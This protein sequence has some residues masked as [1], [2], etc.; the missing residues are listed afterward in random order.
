[1]IDKFID[2]LVKYKS[3][4]WCPDIAFNINNNIQDI[5]CYLKNIKKNLSHKIF[6]INLSDKIYDDNI[7]IDIQNDI[8]SIKELIKHFEKLKQNI[9]DIT[10]RIEQK[11]IFDTQIYLYVID[12]N[13]CPECNVKLYPLYIDYQK[14]I[15][16]NIDNYERIEGYECQCCKK[17]FAMQ[18]DIND[19]DFTDTNITLDYRYLK[20]ENQLTFNDVIVLSNLIS[21]TTKEHSLK[22]IIA[23]IPIISANGSIDFIRLNISYCSNCNKYIMLKNDFKEIDGIVACKVIDKTTI[24][25][26]NDSDIIEIKQYESILYQYGYNVK[27][28]DNLS[29]KQRHLILAAVVESGILTR[30]QICSHLD[31]L[32][33]RGSKIEKWKDATKKWRQD[34]H[35]VKGYNVNNLSKILIEKVILKYSQMSLNI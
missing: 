13:L 10:S 3:E 6:E 33:E 16:G 23:Q 17:I 27:A 26:R 21:C 8:K 15:D 4:K 29:D 30:E 28:K 24:R 32:I 14:N 2:I 25:N 12:D 1:M 22:D 31:T 34:R 11:V 35:Y 5:I 18:Y 20:D 19:I 7:I 9:I